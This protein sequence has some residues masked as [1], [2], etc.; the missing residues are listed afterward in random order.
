MGVPGGRL[1]SSPLQVGLSGPLA[2]PPA[3]HHPPPQHRQ[4]TTASACRQAD[5]GHPAPSCLHPP[6]PQGGGTR[7]SCPDTRCSPGT[8]CRRGAPTPCTMVA[9]RDPH[10]A[11]GSWGLSQAV[12]AVQRAPG[13]AGS[14][15]AW[16]HGLTARH[17]APR[18][19][20]RSNTDVAGESHSRGGRRGRH[21]SSE[22]HRRGTGRGCALLATST[23][24]LRDTS[25]P[26]GGPIL[27]AGTHPLPK[28]S[29]FTAAWC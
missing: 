21:E 8:R 7:P 22:L 23:P 15:R 12:P 17:A 16:A 18:L 6:P 20:G 3:P 26:R 5:N 9:P 4:E 25:L 19:V 2:A 28:G 11:A 27:L 24:R 10:H 29:A 14:R 13:R 1:P